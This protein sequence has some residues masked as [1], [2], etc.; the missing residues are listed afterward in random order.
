MN[1]A[2]TIAAAFLAG[3]AVGIVGSVV[4]VVVSWPPAG[5]SQ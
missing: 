2:L 4:Y 5:A 1:G 3:V